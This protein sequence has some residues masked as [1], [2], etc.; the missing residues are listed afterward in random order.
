MIDHLETAHVRVGVARAY[1]AVAVVGA[2][3]VGMRG[4]TTVFFAL[5]STPAALEDVGPLLVGVDR[6]TGLGGMAAEGDEV[7]LACLELLVCCTL[8]ESVACRHSRWHLGGLG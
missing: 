5:A 7:R 6:N 4:V 3:A 2:R 1:A 8:M